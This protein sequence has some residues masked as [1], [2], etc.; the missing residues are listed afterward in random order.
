VNLSETGDLKEATANLY[1]MMRQM[2]KHGVKLI[3]VD[4]IPNTGLGVACN[5]RLKRAAVRQLPESF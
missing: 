5:D 2:D 1:A 4:P 3:L